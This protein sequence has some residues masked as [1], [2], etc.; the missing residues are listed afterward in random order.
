VSK[1]TV[2][3]VPCNIVSIFLNWIYC[4]L[5][6]V[7]SHFFISIVRFKVFD[8][9]IYLFIIY[10]NRL[11]KEVTYRHKRCVVITSTSQ[12]ISVNICHTPA[13]CNLGAMFV[14]VD[15]GTSVRRIAS[16]EGISV[17]HVWRILRDQSLCPYQCKPSVFLSLVPGWCFANAFLQNVL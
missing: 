16:A 8:H 6:S 2:T 11:L 12:N 1:I 7:M 3:S 14:E 15:H 9:Y 17:P 10:L 5:L 13:P 4:L